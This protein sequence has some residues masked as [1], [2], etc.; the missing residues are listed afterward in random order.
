MLNLRLYDFVNHGFG[1]RWARSLHVFVNPTLLYLTAVSCG[2]PMIFRGHRIYSGLDRLHSPFEVDLPEQASFMMLSG[3][4]MAQSTLR[5][6]TKQLPSLQH[7]GWQLAKPTAFL[8]AGCFA[9]R[10]AQACK[11]MISH[12][13]CGVHE[14]L[15]R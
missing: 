9:E 8:W 7:R 6:C 14:S 1:L 2:F 3:A 11:D 13:A 5:R 12:E 10:L 15:G 4:K